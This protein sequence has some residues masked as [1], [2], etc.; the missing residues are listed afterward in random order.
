MDHIT[1]GECRHRRGE[2]C[3]LTMTKKPGGK[4]RADQWCERAEVASSAPVV[5]DP[6]TVEVVE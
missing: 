1:C 3:A 6:V 4:V 5:V 2:Q